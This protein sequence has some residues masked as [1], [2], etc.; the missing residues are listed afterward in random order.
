M[1]EMFTSHL[2]WE[3]EEFYPAFKTV[4]AS[5]KTL[6][7]TLNKEN[8]ELQAVTNLVT[9]FIGKHAGEEQREEFEADC[10]DLFAALTYRVQREESLFFPEYDKA[11]D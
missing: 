10:D 5:D 11:V 1:E 4:L 7:D 6:L 3:D 8:Q 2:Q 9:E